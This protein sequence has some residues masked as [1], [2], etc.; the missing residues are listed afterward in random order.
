VVPTVV[1]RGLQ[2]EG[3]DVAWFRPRA[4]TAADLRSA[5]LV[6]ALD[7]DVDRLVGDRVPVARWNGLPAVTVN[8][9]RARD[10]IVARVRALVDSLAAREKRTHPAAAQPLR[11]VR[12]SGRGP[13]RP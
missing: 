7:A 9:P 2:R 3:F 8:Y 10:S 13:T 11:P 5:L 1:S 4:L 6:V 12:I